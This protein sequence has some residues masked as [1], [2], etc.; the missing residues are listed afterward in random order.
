M[1]ALFQTLQS[2]VTFDSS[3]QRQVLIQGQNFLDWHRMYHHLKLKA[4]A[5]KRSNEI[6]GD[7]RRQ[8]LTTFFGLLDLSFQRPP[9]LSS[10]WHT[11]LW[12]FR[13]VLRAPLWMQLVANKGII[14]FHTV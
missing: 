7:I 3:C 12:G 14:I 2:S 10:R 8:R 13:S 1:K 4:L 11:I 6:N 5:T 9:E